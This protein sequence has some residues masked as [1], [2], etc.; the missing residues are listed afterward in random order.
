[1]IYMVYSYMTHWFMSIVYV[2]KCG[3]ISYKNK[4]DLLIHVSQQALWKQ[5]I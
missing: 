1:M 3:V 2:S 4:Y 5:I